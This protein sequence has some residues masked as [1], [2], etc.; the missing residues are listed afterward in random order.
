MAYQKL[1]MLVYSLGSGCSA[2]QKIGG[3]LCVSVFFAWVGGE[4]R[5]TLAT[6]DSKFD[7]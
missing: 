2:P 1:Q 3:C 6:S 7:I 4:G 5:V